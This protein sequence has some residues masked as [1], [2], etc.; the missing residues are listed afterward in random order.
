MTRPSQPASMRVWAPIATLL[1]AVVVVLLPS[2]LAPNAEPSLAIAAAA[3]ALALAALRKVGLRDLA[4]AARTTHARPTRGDDVPPVL[5]GRTTDP[6]H[7]PLRP[8]APGRG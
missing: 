4:L 5:A 3:L 2:V 8:R 6:L 7:H 1:G